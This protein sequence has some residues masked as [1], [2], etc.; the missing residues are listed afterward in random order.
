MREAGHG[1]ASRAARRPRLRSSHIALPAA[2]L[3]LLALSHQPAAACWQ[4]TGEA[5]AAFTGLSPEGDV[6]LPGDARG[7]LAGIRIAPADVGSADLRALLAAWQGQALHDAGAAQPDRWARRAVVVGDAGRGDDLA[8]T[9]VQHGLAIVW[10]PDLPPNCRIRYLQAERQARL[11]RRGRWAVAESRLLEAA[12]GARVALKAGEVVVMEGKVMHVGQTRTTT[13]LNFGARQ[14]GASAE[15]AMPVWRA[16]ERQGWTTQSL[17]GQNVRVR[18]VASLGRPARV[19]V[20]D[21]ALI[22]FQE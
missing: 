19:L 4:G 10:P 3:L 22:E 2:A 18:G 1:P 6:M 17:R 8:L 15:I 14:V 20:D 16:L 7:Q 9:L 11:V 13:Y 21:A 5:L 12:D